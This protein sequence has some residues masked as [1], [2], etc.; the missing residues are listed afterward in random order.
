MASKAGEKIM[1]TAERQKAMGADY[2]DNIAEAVRRAA[3]EF[4]EPG[5]RRL[6]NTSAMPPIRWKPCRTRF[7][8]A[9]SRR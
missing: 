1:D 5:A 7:A 2:V 8:G 4:D 9:I 3:G 6:R